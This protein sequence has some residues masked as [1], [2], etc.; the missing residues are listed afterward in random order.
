MQTQVLMLVHQASLSGHPPQP[1]H[2]N[3]DS[4]S[5]VTE[6]NPGSSSC[7]LLSLSESCTLFVVYALYM[8][9][10]DLPILKYSFTTCLENNIL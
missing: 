10:I 1:K 5:P 2:I 3:I 4:E 7:C 9:Y 6:F 8:F